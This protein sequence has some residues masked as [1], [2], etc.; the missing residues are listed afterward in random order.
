MNV[1]FDT[2][3]T[4]TDFGKRVPLLAEAGYPDGFTDCNGNRFRERG[5]S[6]DNH[7]EC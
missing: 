5:P 3:A 1:T 2:I 4:A 6:Y 7:Q